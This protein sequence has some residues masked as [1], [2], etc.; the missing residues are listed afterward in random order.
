M[1]RT[2]RHW[3]EKAR[4]GIIR[5]TENRSKGGSGAARCWPIGLQEDRGVS[6]VIRQA[7]MEALCGQ[8][9]APDRRKPLR[10]LGLWNVEH[11]SSD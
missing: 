5:K 10:F 6:A 3:C 2:T 11:I 9:I 7:L 4:G 8:E 1:K